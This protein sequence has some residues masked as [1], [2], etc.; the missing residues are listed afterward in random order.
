MFVSR[1]V[2][3][4]ADQLARFGKA[5][6]SSFLWRFESPPPAGLFSELDFFGFVSCNDLGL[7]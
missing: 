4:T 5:I 6:T 7:A 1:E 3:V 2:N